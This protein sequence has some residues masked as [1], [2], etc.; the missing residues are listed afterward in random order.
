LEARTVQVRHLSV[1]HDRHGDD[2]EDKA[3]GRRHLP[4]HSPRQLMIVAREDLAGTPAASGLIAALHAMADNL[5]PS[6]RTSSACP[7]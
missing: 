5:T 6:P 3:D 7:G 1:D 4:S 2:R